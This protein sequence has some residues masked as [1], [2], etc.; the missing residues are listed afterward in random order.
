LKAAEDQVKSWQWHLELRHEKFKKK[1]AVEHK[2]TRSI[3]GE[4]NRRDAR[5][6]EEAMRAYAKL[7]E[8]K[9]D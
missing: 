8:S 3:F 6:P 1:Q 5:T 7:I 4:I 2:E 9:P